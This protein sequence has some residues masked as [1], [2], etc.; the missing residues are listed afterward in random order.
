MSIKYLHL[1]VI[2]ISWLMAFGVAAWC[3]W[4]PQ[5]A[6]QAGESVTWLGILCTL[7][8]VGLLVYTPLAWAKLRKIHVG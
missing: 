3:F 4:A 2:C 8:G 1:I 7:L 6:F 5:A